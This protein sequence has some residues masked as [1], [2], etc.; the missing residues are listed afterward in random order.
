MSGKFLLAIILV[1][2]LQLAQTT[3]LSADVDHPAA[4]VAPPVQAA[5]TA[6]LLDSIGVASTFPDR[7]QPIER[8][9]QMVNYAGFRWVRGGIEGLTENGPTSLETFLKLNRTTGARVSWGL[10]SGGFDL[11]QLLR[12]ARVLAGKGALL[13]FEGNNEPNNW[14]VTY[15]GETGGGLD[16]SWLPVARLQRDLYR[17]VKADPV[18]ASYPVWS[19]SEP[20]AQTDNVG[21]QYLEIPAG[22]STLMPDGT[23]FADFANV[24]NY[25]YHPQSPLPMD[26]KVWNAADPS[27]DSLVDGLFGN[28][29][30]TWR[31]GFKGYA[32]DE[33]DSLPRVSTETGT[34]ITAE[35][36]EEMQ[37]RHLVNLYLA[38]FKRGVSFT[39][40][41]LLRDRTD[42]SGNQ[43]FGFFRPDY[44]PRRAAVYMHN[45]TTILADSGR[46]TSPERL[47]YAIPA[48]AETTHDL[49]LQRSDGAF[50][51]VIWG[52]RL[53]GE[54]KV[55]IFFSQPHQRV[56]VFDVTAGTAPV[57]KLVD[58]RRISLVISDHPVVLLIHPE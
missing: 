32:Q 21:L 52:E 38:Q 43:K 12:T 2:G 54:D 11:A 1:C 8:T 26:N 22:A 23:R 18:L 33:L 20:G 40:V 6:D 51:L 46:T 19:I 9:I 44:T 45:L 35:V 17:Q 30:V 13:A 28:F 10:G 41:Y 4:Q 57:E 55:S 16:H 7:G 5:A 14:T 31:K 15:Q 3:F 24:H 58:V 37:G 27:K 49:L 36:T 25:I 29:G 50:Q 53:Q 56:Q 47:A 34:A 42:E 39:S 48:Q